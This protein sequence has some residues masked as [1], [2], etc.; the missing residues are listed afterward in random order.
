MIGKRAFW[1][2]AMGYANAAHCVGIGNPPTSRIVAVMY[3]DAIDIPFGTPELPEF[4]LRV[5]PS[6]NMPVEFRR[7]I[8]LLDE[9]HKRLELAVTEVSRRIDILER[10]AARSESR[11]QTNE[12]RL[13]AIEAGPL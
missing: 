10:R 1:W 5:S 2:F 9:Y 12:L 13:E 8:Q 3:G 6:G 11:H 7:A 4:A